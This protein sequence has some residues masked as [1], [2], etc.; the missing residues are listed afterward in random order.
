MKAVVFDIDRTLLDSDPLWRESLQECARA[1]GHV[2]TDD[3]IERWHCID[4]DSVDV[5][6][7]LGFDESGEDRVRQWC[8]NYAA[9]HAATMTPLPGAAEMVQ[10]LAKEV[11]VAAATASDR[12]YVD[13]AARAFPDI[14]DHFAAVITRQDVRQQKPD[15]EAY[16][17][18]AAALGIAPCDVIAV[19]D[20]GSGIKSAHAAGMQVVAIPYARYPIAPDVLALADLVQP[21]A[22]KAVPYLLTMLKDQ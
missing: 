4:G 2:P 12:D 7:K 22:Y 11:P 19:E 8:V 3:D 9:R 21:D 18:A 16:L 20:S 17:K 6:Q 15:P 13:A 14:F 10:R 5:A 1:Q